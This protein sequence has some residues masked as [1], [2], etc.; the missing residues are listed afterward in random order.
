M[1]R[2]LRFRTSLVLVAA[3]LGAVLNCG[4]SEFPLET[5]TFTASEGLVTP[6]VSGA[7]LYLTP[8]EGL[9][10]EPPAASSRPLYGTLDVGRILRLDESQ[11]TGR[12]YDRLLVDLNGNG[13][14]ADDKPYPAL[15]AKRTQSAS[16]MNRTFGPVQMASSTNTD[17]GRPAFN[18]TLTLYNPQG[19]SKGLVTSGSAAGYLITKPASYLKA[20]VEL[21][22]M[23]ETVGFLDGNGNL[24]LGDTAQFAD[25][26]R[27]KSRDW[28][29][30]R[31]D[32]VF[33]DKDGS[34]KFERRRVRDELELFSNQ[35]YF[36]GKPFKVSFPASG[37]LR[38]E[39][40]TEV[41]TFAVTSDCP[42]DSLVLLQRTPDAKW[43]V[44]VPQV[45]NNKVLV[46]GGVYRLFSCSYSL[47]R[48]KET[49]VGLG[50][51]NAAGQEYSVQPGQTVSLPC[52]P[53][54]KATVTATPNPEAHPTLQTL[55]QGDL[56]AIILRAQLC[57]AGGE[58]YTAFYRGPRAFKPVAPRFP[59]YEISSR[60]YRN[61][62][63]TLRG[64]SD[65]S[66]AKV[67]SLPRFF[68]N[69]SVLVTATFDL[70]T[71]GFPSS[72]TATTPLVIK[73]P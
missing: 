15:A 72:A 8:P 67:V 41:G 46:P 12:G 5:V 7:L 4:G 56:P 35:I 6:G 22:G 3:G 64:E 11:G 45:I 16:S 65:G 25:T 51:A 70:N 27:F 48:G 62:T 17:D 55:I 20:R 49:F 66:F 73:S 23:T 28:E 31:A 1:H 54:L 13:S 21:D 32:Y 71:L 26:A 59:S 68:N 19:L 42:L 30:L 58:T 14:L 10:E 69:Q 47:T 38:L 18:A 57:G 29:W 9:H 24:R 60:A 63:G 2:I 33:R 52:G 40:V 37:R 50:F 44:L 43:Q 39:P 34:G 53:P 61:Y 36:S